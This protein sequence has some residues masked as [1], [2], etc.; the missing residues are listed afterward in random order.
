MKVLTPQGRVRV[1]HDDPRRHRDPLPRVQPPQSV[2]VPA[3]EREQN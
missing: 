1:M 3:S 2:A